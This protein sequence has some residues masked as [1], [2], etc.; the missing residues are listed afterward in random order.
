LL[1]FSDGHENSSKEARLEQV[2]AAVKHQEE[3]YSWKFL[4]FGMDIDAAVGG[5][6]LGM[7]RG[8]NVQKGGGGIMRGVQAASAYVG[9]SRLGDAKMAQ[10]IEH[11][12][13]VDDAAARSATEDFADLIKS[14]E[15]K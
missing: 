4:F 12:A 8:L 11:S 15:P 7:S 3:A 13:A 6:S 10:R 14:K 9:Y 5:G 2:R 1:V